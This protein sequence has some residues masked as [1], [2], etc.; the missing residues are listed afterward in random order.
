MG[1]ELLKH[2]YCF[3]LPKQLIPHNTKFLEHDT[4]SLSLAVSSPLSQ[5]LRCWQTQ[6]AILLGPVGYQSERLIS[7]GQE[8]KEG[9]QTLD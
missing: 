2:C 6:L 8:I 7:T 4:L 1:K 3:L 9:V 5:L